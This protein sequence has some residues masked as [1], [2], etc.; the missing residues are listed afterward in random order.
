LCITAASTA[1]AR[2]DI[3][4][5]ATT[6]IK[7]KLLEKIY[8]EPPTGRID[9]SIWHLTEAEITQALINR[10]NEGLQIRVIGDRAELFELNAVSKNEFYKLAN[11]GVPIRVRVNPTWFPEI[12]HW[13][14]SIFAEQ[15]YVAFGS[16]NYTPFELA[17]V[18]STNYKD[19]TVLFTSDPVIVGA[20]KTK[21]DQIWND[22]KV[23]P[24]SLYGDPPYL[25]DWDEACETDH[26][27][28]CDDFHTQYPNAPHIIPDKQRLEPDN[29]LPADLIF[30][31]GSTFNNRLVQEINKENTLV[32]FV[33]FRLTVP[34]IMNALLNKWASGVPV[35]LLIEPQEYTNRAWPEFWQT[36]A[37]IDKLWAAGVPIKVRAHQGLTH[38]KT[39]VTSTYATNASSNYAAAWQR[40]VNYF[41]PKAEKPAIYQAIKDRVTAM[42]NDPNA[43]TTFHPQ[44]ADAPALSSPAAGSTAS[45]TPT[46]VWDRAPFATEYA[47]FL[48]TSNPPTQVATV[49]AQLGNDP[50]EKYS[51]T[52][53]T[54]LPPGVYF[55]KIVSRTFATTLDPST[56]ASSPVRSFTVAATPPPPTGGP[57]PAPWTA[58]DVG[59]V[60]KAGSSSYANGTFNI[61]GAGANIWGT[62][63]SFHFVSQA[64]SGDTQIVARITRMDNTSTFAKAGVMIRASTAADAPHV[65]LDVRPTGDIEF[66]TRSQ[67]GGATTWLAGANQA[68]PVFLRLARVGA[69]VTGSVSSNGTSWTTVGST[70]LSIGASARAGMIVT[71]QDTNV[72]NTSTFDSAAVGAPGTPPPPPPP[73]PTLPAPWS[74]DDVGA[75]GKPGGTSYSNGT[76]TVSGAGANIWGTADSFHF[77]SQPVSG[78]TQIVARVVT[79]ENTSTFA[80]AGV[81]IRASTAANAAHV[82]LDV[83]PTG[84]IEFMTRS[85]AGGA[86]TWLAGANRAAPVWLRL[87]RSGTTVTGSFS[88]NGSSW[89]TVGST[90]LAIAASARA[91]LIVTSQDTNRLNT[92]TFDSAAVGGTQPPPPTPT[93]TAS[94][95]VVYAGDIPLA[96]LHGSWGITN[97][98]TAAGGKRLVTSDI[99]FQQLNNP[100]ASPTE[101]VD[102]DV[103]GVAG[104]PYTSWLRLQAASNSKFNDAVWV[105]FSNARVNGAPA[106]ATQSTS[107]LLVNLA[108]DSTATSLVNWGW[109]NGAYWLAQPATVTFATTG[110]QRLRIQVREDGVQLDQIVLSPNKYLSTPPGTVT[111]DM[112]I[113]PKP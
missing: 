97:D 67:S 84:D 28:S 52:V 98:S 105:Q 8:A 99:G 58:Q 79:M 78:D 109:Q 94:E 65:I 27:N 55:W 113:V 86:T 75:V 9:I 66:M 23:E 82:I 16:A 87:V 102:V 15:G 26:T 108:T 74:A 91:G 32:Q 30:G 43:F 72:L 107:G 88:T 35:Q 70:T 4:F 49:T 13:K 51:W 25:K 12:N 36:H 54:A 2:D 5:S 6:D 100:L 1:E 95:I 48:S 73:P 33:I 56:A 37:F 40:D 3:Y 19:E 81:M 112:T 90:T 106:Y 62:A 22:T 101:Y 93:E 14:V 80:K 7:A 89:T 17:P 59:A 76:F 47:V 92:S 77:V 64:V 50:P 34:N 111:N 10:F 71:S 21:F 42:W 68:T 63:D 31:Q 110:T 20:I 85:Q 39:L 103:P 104:V 38:M 24:E 61:T 53:P 60:G 46:L 69:T 57:V 83:R 44:P 18:S 11:A 41:I 29:P 45:T 96:N